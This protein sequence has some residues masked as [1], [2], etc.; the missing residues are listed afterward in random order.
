MRA[1]IKQWIAVN[2][3]RLVELKLKGG[4]DLF[5]NGITKNLSAEEIKEFYIL[6]GQLDALIWAFL[7]KDEKKA[8]AYRKRITKALTKIEEEIQIIKEISGEFIL[9][10]GIA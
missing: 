6:A 10:K 9:P 4:L 8:I 5:K 2:G 3:R 1:K 7:P